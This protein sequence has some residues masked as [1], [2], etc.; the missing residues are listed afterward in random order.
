MRR[1]I[2]TAAF[3]CTVVLGGIPPEWSEDEKSA[4]LLYAVTDVDVKAQFMPAVGNGYIGTQIGSDSMF[5]SG[6]YNGIA[7]ETPSHRARIPSTVAF[8]GPGTVEHTALN[9]R[10]VRSQEWGSIGDRHCAPSRPVSLWQATYYRRSHIVPYKDAGAGFA[11]CGPWWSRTTGESC[12]SSAQKTWIEQ[13]WYAHRLLRS[14]L[15]HEVRGSSGVAG[16]L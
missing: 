4:N 12:T 10:E 11:P 8:R 9:L 16:R 6:V 5:V 3:C 1:R 14:V 7:S 15:V 2:F 13:R